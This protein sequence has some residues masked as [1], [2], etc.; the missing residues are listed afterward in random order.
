MPVFRR[1][2]GGKIMVFSWLTRVLR[3]ASALLTSIPLCKSLRPLSFESSTGFFGTG[4]A[5]F[6]VTPDV[7]DAVDATLEAL[8]LS[9]RLSLVLPPLRLSSNEI[10]VSGSSGGGSMRI[11]PV[12]G[13][14]S[15]SGRY[16]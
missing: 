2:G 10:L 6:C 4:G 7:D 8:D 11:G 1:G 5:A 13:G 14:F 15:A 3:R 12:A 16:R 9:S